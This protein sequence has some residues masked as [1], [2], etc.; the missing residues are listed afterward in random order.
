MDV[1]LIRHAPPDVAAGIC[2]GSL[3]VPLAAPPSPT[4][5]QIA[6]A[7]P[8]VPPHRLIAS[9]MRRAQETAQGMLA[10]CAGLP[11][12]ETE[13][14]LR[15]MDFGAWEGRAWDDI[16]RHDLDA[17]A[18]DLHHA[19]PHGGES[20]AQAGARVMAWAEGLDVSR[21]ECLWV[22][23]HAGP[24]RL[25][26]SQWLGVPLAAALG[27]ELGYGASS[28]VRLGAHA[29]RLLWWNRQA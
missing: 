6:A 4:P 1:V 29:P 2:Y 8:A 16:P 19:R 17:W 20:A 28:C 9:P 12:I 26:V 23:G 3:D 13:P 7:L 24:M 21:D 25:L 22:I 27:W 11:P 5:A 14:L 18:A 10:A 15:E